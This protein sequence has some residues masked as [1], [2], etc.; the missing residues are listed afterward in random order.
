MV[1]DFCGRVYDSKTL[2]HQAIGRNQ[3]LRILVLRIES[4]LPLPKHALKVV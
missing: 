4:I 3:D 2:H 1:L